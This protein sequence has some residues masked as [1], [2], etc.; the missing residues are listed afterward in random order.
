VRPAEVASGCSAR[1]AR[2]ICLLVC[3]SRAGAQAPLASEHLVTVH[4]YDGRKLLFVLKGKQHSLVVKG[5]PKNVKVRA[6]RVRGEGF[7]VLGPAAR[8]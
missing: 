6:V 4:L 8:S 1:P 2:F 3:P 7:G 5:V